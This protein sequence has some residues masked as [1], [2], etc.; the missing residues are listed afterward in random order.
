MAVPETHSNNKPQ[1]APLAFRGVSVPSLNK[2]VAYFEL[3]GETIVSEVLE[4]LQQRG[5]T[6]CRVLFEDTHREIVSYPSIRFLVPLTFP[7]F[8]RLTSLLSTI[9]LP[10]R[11]VQHPLTNTSTILSPHQSTARCP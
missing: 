8:F 2:A 3:P 10:A 1:Q 6:V 7:S 5:T 11:S 4:E 9:F